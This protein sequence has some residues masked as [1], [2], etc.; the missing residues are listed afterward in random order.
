MQTESTVPFSYQLDTKNNNHK[1]GS[2]K[3]SKRCYLQGLRKN[4]RGN[5][6]EAP[7]Q[8]TFNLSICVCVCVSPSVMSDSATLWTLASQAP[9]SMEFSRQEYWSGL[10]NLY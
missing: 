9:Q 2:T 7:Y 10:P 8:G 1:R 4:S 6:Y 5:N 3:Q